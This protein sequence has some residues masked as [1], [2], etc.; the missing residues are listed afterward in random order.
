MATVSGG[1]AVEAMCFCIRS[2]NVAVMH[3][4]CEKNR[5]L[6]NLQEILNGSFKI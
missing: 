5:Q 4:D 2:R 6:I 1:E 3:C